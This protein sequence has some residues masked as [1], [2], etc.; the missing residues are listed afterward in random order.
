MKIINLEEPWISKSDREV[1]QA[2]GMIIP[3]VV[4]EELSI[5]DLSYVPGPGDSQSCSYFANITR[6]VRKRAQAF[7]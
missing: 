3:L 5:P 4:T 6:F 7:L 2:G 1:C